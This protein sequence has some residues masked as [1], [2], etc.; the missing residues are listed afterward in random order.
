KDILSNRWTTEKQ[1]ERLKYRME[2]IQYQIKLQ[3]ETRDYNLG[4]SLRNYIDPRIM[5]TWLDYV[6]LDWKK[7][8]T[9]TLQ[10]KFKWVELSKR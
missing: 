4:T 2:K 6:A 5:K 9:T 8:Y 7:I 1:K 3:K 10:R